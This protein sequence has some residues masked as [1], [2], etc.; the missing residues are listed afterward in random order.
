[1]I[2]GM[3]VD[4]ERQI[5][6]LILALL[7]F[8]L[9]ATVADL[10]GLAHY[11]EPWQIVPIAFIS[12]SLLVLLWHIVTGSPASLL[13]L[14][15]LMPVLVLVGMVGVVLHLK[16]SLAFQLEA[17]PDLAGWVLLKK[18]LRAKAPPALAPGVLVQLG[19]LGTIYGYKHPGGR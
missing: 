10:F 5:R 11:E 4:L 14:R 6:R 3:S 15:L 19:L 18:L 17:N 7:T 8:G 12:F 16:G 9:A 1:M 2:R 13:T